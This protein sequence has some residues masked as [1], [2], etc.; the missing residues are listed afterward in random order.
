L[1]VVILYYGCGGSGHG[2]R[3]CPEINEL[4]K[5]GV[6]IQDVDGRIKKKDI[7]AERRINIT[8]YWTEYMEAKRSSIS[9]Y[10]YV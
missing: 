2:L 7:H 4:L 1:E 9:L 3:D 10:N 6:M 5:A 8:S